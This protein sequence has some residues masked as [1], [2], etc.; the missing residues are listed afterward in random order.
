MAERKEISK[1]VGETEEFAVMQL[2]VGDDEKKAVRDDTQVSGCI[3][4]SV[5]VLTTHSGR[6]TNLKRK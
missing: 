4:E 1:R 3:S 2:D 5:G 6:G